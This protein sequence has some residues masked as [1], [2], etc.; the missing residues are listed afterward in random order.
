M[1][2]TVTMHSI[3]DSW[4]IRRSVYNHKI[5]YGLTRSFGSAGYAVTAV[6]AGKLFD[7]YG[8]SNTFYASA[9]FAVIA[10]IVAFSINDTDT[11]RAHSPAEPQVSVRDLAASV[12]KNPVYLSFIIFGTVF[13]IGL[14]GTYTFYPVLLRHLGGTNTNLGWYMFVMAGSEIPMFI[15]SKKIINRFR[16]GTVLS[17]TMLLYS[18]RIG[19][20]IVVKSVSGLILIQFTQAFTY[21]LYIPSLIYFVYQVAPGHFKTAYQTLA[22]AVTTGLGNI[23]GSFIGGIVVDNWGIYPYYWFATVM[24]FTGAAGFTVF[25]LLSKKTVNLKEILTLHSIHKAALQLQ[26]KQDS[27]HLIF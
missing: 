21:A 20:H 13:G 25:S 16:P 8:L 3:I 11:S 15:L 22:V 12:I 27:L 24:V 7:I 19:L 6:I 4:T 10:A 23:L 1:F 17:A 2:V 18:L 26:G 9:A 5:N 14:Q